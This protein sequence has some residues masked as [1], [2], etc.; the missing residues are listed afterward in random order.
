M[1]WETHT[2]SAHYYQPNLLLPFEDLNSPKYQA[3][4]AI[5]LF[6][7][8]IFHIVLLVLFTSV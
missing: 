6:F 1:G 8:E 4:I 5:L 2:Q 3:F 7:E